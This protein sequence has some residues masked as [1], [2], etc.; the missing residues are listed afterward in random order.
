MM[1]STTDPGIDVDG[2]A[3]N[4]IRDTE[5]LLRESDRIRL[6]DHGLVELDDGNPDDPVTM[7]V[8]QL[9]SLVRVV[10]DTRG[11]EEGV[12]PTPRSD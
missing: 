11:Y 2:A 5:R 4:V 8:N 6:N 7:T 1:S 12:E 3:C 10:E 9:R